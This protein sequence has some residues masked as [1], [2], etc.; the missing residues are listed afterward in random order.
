[1][2][3]SVSLAA[4][5][6]AVF[7]V[8]LAQTPGRVARGGAANFHPDNN[9]GVASM[10][11]RRHPSPVEELQID[12]APAGGNKGKMPIEWEHA[13]ATVDVTGK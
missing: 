5:A 7:V 13:T 12:L 6:V 11:L 10:T 8:V 4:A 9:A 2:K 3:R 1:M